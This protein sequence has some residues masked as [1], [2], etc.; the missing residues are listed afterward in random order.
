MKKISSR[1]LICSLLLGSIPYGVISGTQESR[2]EEVASEAVGEQNNLASTVVEGD[3]LENVSEIVFP[4]EAI[5][6]QLVEEQIVEDP[7]VAENNFVEVLEVTGT[8]VPAVDPVYA[9]EQQQESETPG[10]I[11]GISPAR[12]SDF[13][14]TV[15][16]AVLSIGVGGQQYYYIGASNFSFT[17]DDLF[18]SSFTYRIEKD[19]VVLVTPTA[20]NNNATIDLA[21]LGFVSEGVYRIVMVG[22][23]SVGT[24]T[25]TGY[26]NNLVQRTKA[27][28]NVGGVINDPATVVENPATIVVGKDATDTYGD[29]SYTWVINGPNGFSLTGTGRQP[30]T[31]EINGLPIGDYT[32]TNTV[33]EVTP[34][35]YGSVAMT[36][37]KEGAFKITG[38]QVDV[39]HILVDKAGNEVS[40]YETSSQT[41]KLGANYQ[42]T[43]LSILGYELVPTKM[44]TNPT[45]QFTTAVQKV[46]YYYKKVETNIIVKY[47]DEAGNSLATTETMTDEYGSTYGTTA[48]NILGYELVATPV[49]ANGVYETANQEVVY[50]YK[51]VPSKVTV[52]YV[53]QNGLSVANSSEIN[54]LYDDPYTTKPAAVPG[55][56]LVVIPKNASGNYV[57]DPTV[58][59][60]VY[61][62][63]VPPTVHDSLE[64]A[65]FVTG[66]GVP[67]KEVVVTFPDGSKITV[68]VDGNG[69]WYVRVP[70]GVSLKEG[71]KISA[72]TKDPLTGML[73]DEGLGKVIPVPI[74]DNPVAPIINNN[75][76]NNNNNNNNNNTNNTNNNNQTA[77]TTNTLPNTTTTP[78]AKKLPSTGEQ[79]KVG[80]TVIGL[81]FLL[82]A[83][84]LRAFVLEKAKKNG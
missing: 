72:V 44:P 29:Y 36:D 32:I 75:T 77:N 49:N 1:F 60:Y 54:G 83:I 53:D 31:A 69:N 22:Y 23:D 19:G 55:Y 57:V 82:M 28:V 18:S 63:I 47:V 12:S 6:E 26:L 48:K 11:I 51:K 74:I 39:E 78:V 3:L 59:T 7:T 46:S 2:A 50:V 13:T 71:D 33:T 24:D 5:E 61:A 76:N 20:V 34:P 67:G 66:V 25:D 73:S 56:M 35:E 45:G 41:G 40:V 16:G 21:G 81:L 84:K 8:E 30:T 37:I 9:E 17:R 68:S 80:Y 4:L 15:D 38:G 27:M 65:K 14:L 62:E 64:N 58:V 42:T 10:T 79:T 70:E 52:N 43:A